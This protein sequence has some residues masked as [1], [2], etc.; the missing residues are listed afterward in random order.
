MPKTST[1][2]VCAGHAP[3]LDVVDFNKNCMETQGLFLPLSHLPIYYHMCDQCGHVFS[4]EFWNWSDSDFSQKI[5]ND[6]YRLVD[7]DYLETRPM[8]NAQWLMQWFGQHT[9]DI[10]HLDYG[11]GNGR[12]SDHLRQHGWNSTSFDP[13]PST[14][15]EP[16]RLG[17]FNLITAFEVFEHVPHPQELLAHIRRLM[18]ESCLV[19]FSTLTSD[20]ALQRHSRINWWYCAPRNGHISLFTR[21][22]LS[23][24]GAQHQLKFGSLNEGLHCYANQIPHWATQFS[25]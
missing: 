25:I 20:N 5:Y 23:M 1:C 16:E 2:P 14:P 4:P 18:G 17:K 11:G 8:G 13:F 9:A 10:V 7:P 24:L 19:V 22:S 12:L 15:F 3:A 6:D 21:K